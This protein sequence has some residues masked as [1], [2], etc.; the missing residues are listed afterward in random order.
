MTPEITRRCAS[1]LFLALAL[2]TGFGLMSLPAFDWLGP[3][4]RLPGALG[5]L[6][7][8]LHAGLAWVCTRLV[9][10]QLAWHVYPDW[11]IRGTRW[12]ALVLV[13]AAL[14][15]W[16][17]SAWRTGSADGRGLLWLEALVLWLWPAGLLPA[18]PSTASASRSD[19]GSDAAEP[20]QYRWHDTGTMKEVEVG[21]GGHM[22]LS[23]PRQD[24][25]MSRKN[26]VVRLAEN[27]E[28]A[29]PA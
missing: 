11:Q 12:L 1:L 28:K 5:G 17:Q 2:A 13:G 9:L 6:A 29:L 20:A 10:R 22:A 4:A 7:F 16:L 18:A 26:D 27:T 15:W 19:R 8:V 23:R 24:R 3:V 14:G 25:A 21:S